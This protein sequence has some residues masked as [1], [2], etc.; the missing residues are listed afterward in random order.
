MVRLSPDA[1]KPAGWIEHEGR[2][3][4]DPTVAGAHGRGVQLK[5]HC[6]IRTECK[7]TV[8]VDL[9]WQCQRGFGKA[10]LD[11]LK[12]HYRCRRTPWCDMTWSETYPEGT[13]I[14]TYLDSDSMI[15]IKCGGCGVKQEH[16]ADKVVRQLV[17][18][19]VGSN[20]GI[21]A[22]ASHFSR[23]CTCGVVKWSA[24]VVAPPRIKFGD[25]YA[26]EKSR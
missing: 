14:L 12:D 21:R 20:T 4:P 8:T 10:L 26:P 22:L 9:E 24:E 1:G 2:L 13:P 7:R 23:P 6:Y 3:V 16:C 17:G 19:G 25:A 11:E 5:G 18:R 15:V